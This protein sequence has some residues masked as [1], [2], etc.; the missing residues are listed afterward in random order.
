MSPNLEEARRRAQNAYRLN[1]AMSKDVL[2]AVQLEHAEG[3]R[4][5]GRVDYLEA[6]PKSRL[7][8]RYRIGGRW[9]DL[10]AVQWVESR[11][12]PARAGK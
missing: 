10:A 3:P 12:E 6:R 7:G 11:R 5:L 2:V 4:I 1:F 8:P 9:V